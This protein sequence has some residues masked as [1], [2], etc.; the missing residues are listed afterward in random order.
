M[1]PMTNQETAVSAFWDTEFVPM[2]DGIRL[3]TETY[4]ATGN[5]PTPV[6][7][8][9]TPYSEPMQRN[10]PIRTA[11]EAGFSVVIQYCRGSFGSEGELVAFENEKPDGLDSLAWLRSREWC[12]GN[13]VML[14]QSYLG[15]TQNAIAG[16]MPGGL[17]GMVQMVTTHNYRD[18]L[19]YQQGAFQLG[20]GLGW[21]VLKVAQTLAD[22]P[23]SNPEEKARLVQA[24]RS[25][26]G[27]L[28]EAYRVL[29][30]SNLPAINEVLPTWRK[31]VENETNQ[32]YW[33][34]FSFTDERVKTNVPV[35]HIGGWYDLFLSGTLDN[36]TTISTAAENVSIRASQHLIIGPWT[37]TDQTGNAGE[38]FYPAGN[39]AV[40]GL[41][42][43]Q[44]GFL[45]SA[46]EREASSLPPVQL[47]VMG[48][49]I[50]R[51]EQE[52][53]LARTQWQDWNFTPESQLLPPGS[54]VGEGILEFTTDPLDPVPTVGG[55]T[56]MQGGIDGGM[57]YQP[58]T[59]DQR[60]LDGRADILRFVSEPLESDLEVTGPVSATLTVSTS[61]KDADF[62]V[63]LI[64]ER[65]DGRALGVADGI[66]RLR[67]RNGMNH[68]S[69]VEP[70]KEYQ[71]TVS[72]VATS[73]LFA[74]GHRIRIDIAGSNFPCYDRNL[75][76]GRPIAENTAGDIREFSQ[77]L[78]FGPEKT[79]H[80]S[81]P[82]IP[83]T[84]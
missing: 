25:L 33:S 35:L 31:W 73:Q 42:R 41:E 61:A 62:T 47:F 55:R 44:I 76:T 59:R 43:Q 8:M 4:R 50:W 80:L 27:N 66:L 75:G 36:Y 40:F 69:P 39:A 15:M 37:H 38:M 13:V 67:Y 83:C 71:I 32:D 82:V 6:L 54:Q 10:A 56:L 26:A 24:F 53:P 17:A 72:L 16:S 49:N 68:P 84:D 64:D 77:S 21:H 52:W 5:A 22:Q 78:H 20:Q 30:S 29:P 57:H 79:M 9:R 58:G 46:V 19:A 60:I 45:R 65:P 14:G 74:K 70:G 7:F 3:R 48:A 34:S 2:R 51:S 63:R 81:L 12:D 18:G 1:T 28:N 11:L 23:T